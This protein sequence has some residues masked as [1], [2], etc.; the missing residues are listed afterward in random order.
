MDDLCKVSIQEVHFVSVRYTN[1]AY[2]KDVEHATQ[3]QDD[4]MVIVITGSTTKV[5]ARCLEIV[6]LQ[7]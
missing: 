4:T 7:N 3:V 1:E 2:I 6:F 5:I